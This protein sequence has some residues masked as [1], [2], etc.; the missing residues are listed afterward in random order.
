MRIRD[1]CTTLNALRFEA[2]FG[3]VIC[4]HLLYVHICMYACTSACIVL[5]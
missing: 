4:T 2:G 3:V 1:V 5:H